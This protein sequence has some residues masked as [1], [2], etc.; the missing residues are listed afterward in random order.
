MRRSWG[1][2]W[3]AVAIA[4]AACG[5]KTQ[6]SGGVDS[7]SVSGQDVAGGQDTG[8]GP[9]PDISGGVAIDNQAMTTTIHVTDN[10]ESKQATLAGM[11]YTPA[12]CT[13]AKPCPLA[14]IVGDYDSE[15]WPKY[16]PGAK[17]LA[18]KTG[19]IVAVFN[20]PGLG[21]GGNISEGT[22]DY[23]GLWQITAVSEAMHQLTARAGV[24]KT[25]TGFI[26]V[27]TGLIAVAGAFKTFGNGALKDV[28]FLIDVEGPVDRCAISQAP[29]DDA[30][31]IGPSDGPGATDSACHYGL[32]PHGEQYPAAKAGNPASIVCAEGAWPI[33]KTGKNCQENSWWIEREP[34]KNL[35]SLTAR[36]WRLQFQYDHR[37]PSTGSSVLALK[38][39]A[40]APSKMF[41]YNDLAACSLP[42]ANLCQQRQAQ[43][44]SCFLPDDQGNG[45][46]PA[47]YS[48][49]KLKPVSI[50][51]LLGGVLPYY[52][53]TI[54]DLKALPN[55]K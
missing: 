45:M 36:Y 22:N 44:F 29:E 55:C 6:A 50:D 9:G 48:G 2:C 43:N 27:G 26:S 40:S 24:D 1:M 33:T 11:I 39:V 15:A 12:T 14:I 8:G 7:G 20:L 30:Q 38:A 17:V 5:S 41:R 46:A 35:A 18:S 32:V 10:G 51:A 34:Y 53:Q 19:A 25:R 31:G 42:T 47:P 13:A 3:M 49:G 23:G 21:Q 28:A 4:L 37:L 52:L 16:G 54:V